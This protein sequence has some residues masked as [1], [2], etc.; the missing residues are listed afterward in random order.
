MRQRDTMKKKSETHTQM[1][2]LQA[3]R[4]DFND[5]EFTANT[6]TENVKPS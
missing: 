6:R 3:R 2:E 1:R 5:S 4:C